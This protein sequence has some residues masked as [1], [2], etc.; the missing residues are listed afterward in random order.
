MESR[1]LK[2]TVPLVPP[3][4]NHYKEPKIIRR[5]RFHSI[6]WQ[7]IPE[8]TI[9]KLTLRS[10]AR[11]ASLAPGTLREQR[12]TRYILR[13][14]V[15][16]GYA[17]SGDGDN[18]WKVIADALVAAGVIHTDSAVDDW[19]LYKRRDRERPRTEIT[20]TAFVQRDEKRG[21]PGRS[22]PIPGPP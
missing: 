17:Q 20:V 12:K 8:A 11:G 22:V 16:L 18:F 21:S 13:A 5:G 19:H 15:F 14:V 7:E 2:I 3:S 6:L 10:L 4:G 9:F 1:R